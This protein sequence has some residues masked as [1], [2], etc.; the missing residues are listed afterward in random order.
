[1]LMLLSYLCIDKDN[2]L[3]YFEKGVQRGED[4][5]YLSK[6]NPEK[7]E[8]LPKPD[9]LYSPIYWTLRKP[10]TC[11]SQTDFTIPST[12]C[13]CNLNLCKPNTCLY[14]TKSSVPKGFGLDKFDCISHQINR[15]IS[16]PLNKLK[17]NTL[18]INTQRFLFHL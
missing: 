6:P 1:M 10:K 2:Y 5:K 12:K 4:S 13:L 8:N 7:T 16:I 9:T 17:F 15:D 14:W 3:F 11:L 18:Q